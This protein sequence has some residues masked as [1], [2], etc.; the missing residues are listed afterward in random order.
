MEWMTIKETAKY[1]RVSVSTIRKF[2]KTGKL[3]SYRQGHIIQ[4]KQ[5]DIDAF[6]TFNTIKP[7]K[8]K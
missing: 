8:S 3:L 2:V 5:S 1:L 4:F 6:L 7:E